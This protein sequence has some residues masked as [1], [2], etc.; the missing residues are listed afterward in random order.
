MTAL[1]TFS[2]AAQQFSALVGRLPAPAWEGPGLGDWDLRSLVG[3]TSRAMSTVAEYLDRPATVIDV[4]SPEEYYARARA[5]IAAGRVT[6]IV[7]RGRQAGLELGTDPAAAVAAQV[8]AVLERLG[9]GADRPIRVMGG[10]GMRLH[11]YLPTRTFELAVH[12]LDI[13]AATGVDLRLP[14]DV[15][16]ETTQLAARTAVQLGAAAP[17]LRALTGRA[18]LPDGFSV[19]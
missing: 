12:S 8:A 10:L 18:P 3:H 16:N 4:E 6:G 19:V 9:D 15:A 7:E 11:A 17:F 1:T 14:M 2:A 5:A 13:A